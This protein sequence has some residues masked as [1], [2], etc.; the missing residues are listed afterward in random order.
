MTQRS[1]RFK[2]PKWAILL[3]CTVF[4][5]VAALGARYW[6]GEKV[7]YLESSIPAPNGTWWYTEHT[8]QTWADSHSKYFIVRKEDLVFNAS[9]ESIIAHFDKWLTN[10]GWRKYGEVPYS[11]CQYALP[12]S[13]LLDDIEGSHLIFYRKR[14]PQDWTVGPKAC[15]AIWP[16]GIG[17]YYVVFVTNNPSWF[18]VFA[19]EVS[20]PK[21]R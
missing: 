5:C 6:W 13:R 4:V 20:H 7:R 12:E 2:L 21:P 19:D 10:R 17:D 18:T 8:T 14:D 11:A 15:L 1:K 3:L 16:A 9:W